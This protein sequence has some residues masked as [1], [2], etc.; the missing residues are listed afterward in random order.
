MGVHALIPSTGSHF[1][2]GGWQFEVV[3][4]GGHRIDKILV[5]RRPVQGW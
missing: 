1:E 3:D 5:E 2:W 4:M